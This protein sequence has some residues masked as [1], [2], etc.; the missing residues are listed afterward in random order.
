M[1]LVLEKC[2]ICG[3]T[4]ET[5]SQFNIGGTIMLSLKCGHQIKQ[6]HL[7][8]RDAAAIKALNGHRLMPFQIKGVEH[9]ETAGGRALI[10]DEMGLG[11]TV[12]ALSFLFLH[13]EA[14]P[15]MG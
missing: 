1:P 8:K 14:M 10:D 3:K 6:E 11:K 9:V 12:Q 5:R 15:A 13:P 2:R 7:Q 4:A